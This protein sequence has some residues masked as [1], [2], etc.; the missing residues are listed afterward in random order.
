MTMKVL[1][2]RNVPAG[3]PVF[4]VGDTDY[5]ENDTYDGDTSELLAI[6]VVESNVAVAEQVVVKEE[7]ETPVP[8]ETNHDAN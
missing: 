6:G 1:N 7:V 5:F 2:P 3:V 4:S 8:E